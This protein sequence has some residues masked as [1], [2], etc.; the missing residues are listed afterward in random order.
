MIRLLAIFII[1]LGTAQAVDLH[2][3]HDCIAQVEDW[4]GRRGR[5]GEIGPTQILPQVWRRYSNQRYSAEE[6][7]RVT[8]AHLVWLQSNVE[9]PTVYRLALAWNAGAAAT[10]RCRINDRQADY[11]QRVRNLYEAAK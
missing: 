8:L 4:Q 2:R 9:N 5:A 7:R 10:N 6:A 1:T 3:L 11:A